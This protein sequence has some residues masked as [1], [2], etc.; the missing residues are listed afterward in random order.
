MISDDELALALATESGQLLL[1][2]REA[3][4]FDDPKALRDA[5]D[6]HSHELLMRRFAAERPDDAV[7]SEEGV[8]DKARL[9]ADRVWIVDPLDGTREYGEQGRTDWAVHVALWVRGT[10]LTAGAVALPASGEPLATLLYT[11]HPPTRPSYDGPPRIVVSRTRAPLWVSAVAE[12]L[13]AETVPM[14]SAGAKIGAVVR[15]EAEIYL[16]GGGQYEWDSAAP[17]AVAL[18]AGLWCSR[19][20]GTPLTYNRADPLLPDLVVC[21]SELAD[22]VLG[23]VAE[24]VA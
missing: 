20:D 17:V 7:L 14:G 2:L 13:G 11:E 21:R 19:L 12:R 16:H 10:G 3:M 23:L 9:A 18:A 1:G 4:G 5:G 24:S 8:D 6:A 22:V 15:G